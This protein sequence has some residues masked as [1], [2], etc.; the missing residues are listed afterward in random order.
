MGGGA[1]ASPVRTIDA[2]P[3]PGFDLAALDL[4]PEAADPR[5]SD[6]FSIDAALEAGRSRTGATP[7][8]QLAR[9][10]YMMLARL[11]G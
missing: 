4:D 11:G 8:P 9:M 6:P 3:R 7:S 2:R 5:D 1:P 10:A